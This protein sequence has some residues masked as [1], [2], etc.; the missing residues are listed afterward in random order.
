MNTKNWRDQAAC[1]G[2]DTKLFYGERGKGKTIYREAR[3]YC[4]TCP[5]LADCFQSVMAAELEPYGSAVRYGYFAGMTPLERK[6]YQHQRNL[7]VY[8]S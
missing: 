8:A 6:Q 4:D 7:N 2:A 5:V 3:K 1:K